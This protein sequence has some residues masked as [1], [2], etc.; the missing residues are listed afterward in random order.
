M[1]DRSRVLPLVFLALASVPAFAQDE[2]TA[3]APDAATEAAPETAPAPA[4]TTPPAESPK[5]A[6]VDSAVHGLFGNFRV[7]PTLAV[8]FPHPVNYG[9][10]FQLCK[11][12]SFN[13]ST[14]KYDLEAGDAVKIQIANWDLRAR[15]HP[16][17]GSFFLGAAYGKQDLV[18]NA[19]KDVKFETQGLKT[20]VPTT[21]QLSMETTY[22]TP[23]L[24]WFA[25]WDVGFTLGFEI[26][27]QVPMSNKT[28]LDVGFENVSPSQEAAVKDS[29][30]FKELE[31]SVDDAGKIMGKTTIPYITLLR[32]GWML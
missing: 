22:L 23:H 6:E 7:G 15:W 31:K 13:F 1:L 11:N 8:G 9:L 26:G 16:F 20:T 21:I 2:E 29:D 30:E 18:A 12:L 4:A 14:G 24:G 19:E 10:D 17:S 32:L 27:A 5:A 25:V 28:D 3:P